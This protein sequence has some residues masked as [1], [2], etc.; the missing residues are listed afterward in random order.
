MRNDKSK[1]YQAVPDELHAHYS[2]T[3]T[4][5][6]LSRRIERDNIDDG[7]VAE[8]GSPGP[9]FYCLDTHEEAVGD[10]RFVAPERWDYANG[11]IIHACTH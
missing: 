10:R 7:S 9:A 3:L 5:M 4:A 1:P 11:T 8:M 2:L 6:L